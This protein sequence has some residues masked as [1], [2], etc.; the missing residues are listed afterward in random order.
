M[1]SSS[2]LATAA[3]RRARF[4]ISRPGRGSPGLRRRSSR[5]HGAWTPGL[6]YFTLRIDLE[7]GLGRGIDLINGNGSGP[8][9]ERIQKIIIEGAVPL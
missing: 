3:L 2:T 7:E 8:T 6:E 9:L 4:W 1:R 5:G